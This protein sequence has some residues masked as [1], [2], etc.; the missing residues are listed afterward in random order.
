VTL[1]RSRE[2]LLAATHKCEGTLEKIKVL[3]L[4]GIFCVLLWMTPHPR[5]QAGRFIAP[6]SVGPN[7]GMALFEID[8]LLDTATGQPCVV[9][10]AEEKYAAAM[11]ADANH[12]AQHIRNCSDLK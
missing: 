6:D 8:L 11:K 1:G 7:G 4:A 2:Q 5:P 3:L 12:L 10:W 9:P